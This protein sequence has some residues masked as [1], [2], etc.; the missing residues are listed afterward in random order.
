M[1]ILYIEH[2]DLYGCSVCCMLET[3]RC[4]F[5]M[6]GTKIFAFCKRM[7]PKRTKIWCDINVENFC[8]GKCIYNVKN[9]GRLRTKIFALGIQFNIL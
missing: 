1:R 6:W 3:V 2:G 8:V 5:Y 4:G 7:C 9:L